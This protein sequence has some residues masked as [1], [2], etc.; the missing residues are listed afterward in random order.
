M[1]IPVVRHAGARHVV[2]SE[3]TRFRR[4]LAE[5]MGATRAVDPTQTDLHDVQEELGM[6]EGFDVVLEMSG[7]PAALQ[8][9]IANMAHGGRPGAAGDPD[10]PH[11]L[12]VHTIVFNQLT[13]RGITAARCT[14]RGTR[15]PCSS[16]PAST[17]GP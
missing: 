4:A 7:H 14:R 16:A 12:D 15:W 5:K 9:A 10:R 8:S 6:V 3:P 17:S 2:V 1:T 13:L 11:H